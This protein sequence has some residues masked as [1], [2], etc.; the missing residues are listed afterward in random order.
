MVADVASTTTASTAMIDCAPKFE[1]NDVDVD[2]NADVEVGQ[3]QL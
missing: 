2:P 1:G 3:R